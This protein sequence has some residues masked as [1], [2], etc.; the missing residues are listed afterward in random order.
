[1][2]STVFGVIGLGVFLLVLSSLWSTLFPAAAKWTPEKAARA[3]A[4]KGKLHNLAFV[5]NS[6]RPNLQAGQDLG[7]LKAEYETLR[8]ENSQLDAEFSS[9]AETP[10]T[11][12]KILK[13]SG[14]S[15]AAVGVVAWYA[16]NQQR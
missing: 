13:W 7:Q 10:Q 4:V 12:S 3:A 11:V 14:I 2:K 1:M 15:L 16:V 6:P 9:A 8:K 5:V